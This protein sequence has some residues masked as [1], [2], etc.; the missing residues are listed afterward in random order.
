M[1]IMSDLTQTIA[2]NKLQEDN[3]VMH[4]MQAYVS[5]DMRAPLTAIMMCVELIL[6]GFN[7]TRDQIKLIDPIRFSAQLLTCQVNN[8]LD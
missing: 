8:L 6:R 7:L 2:I 1:L 4:K 3:E 5:H